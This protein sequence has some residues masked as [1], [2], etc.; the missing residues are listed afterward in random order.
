MEFMKS[1]SFYPFF[2]T[3]ALVALVSG[4]SSIP[5]LAMDHSTVDMEPHLDYLRKTLDEHEF[6]PCHFC[7]DEKDATV[8]IFDI[9]EHQRQRTLGIHTSHPKKESFEHTLP[10]QSDQT[11]QKESFEHILPSQSDQTLQTVSTYSR[12]WNMLP[13]M[14]RLPSL[15]STP[16]PE[17]KDPS[18]LTVSSFY[19]IPDD[20]STSNPISPLSSSNSTSQSSSSENAPLINNHSRRSSET[21][22]IELGL[23]LMGG[24]GRGYMTMLWLKRLMDETKAPIWQIFP[25]VA[26]VSIGAIL[27]LGLANPKIE[28][29]EFDSFF[30]TDFDQV[31]PQDSYW[32]IPVKVW[33]SARTIFYP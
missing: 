21:E 2:T 27:G 17:T 10:S 16:I 6:H 33:D 5:G 12:L 14:P 29:S 24:G 30:T 3:L 7:L 8:K 32:N 19:K 28:I 31:F 15:W 9:N 13:T 1:R 26:G 25:C 20:P 22:P 4:A 18:P 23:S 11:L